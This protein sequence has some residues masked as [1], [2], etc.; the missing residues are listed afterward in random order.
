MIFYSIKEG[1]LGL[2]RAKFAAFISI[3]TISLTLSLLSLFALVT[4]NVTRMVHVVQERVNVELFIDNSMNE[5]SLNILKNQ[6][7]A[8]TEIKQVEY[9]T[10]EKALERF[11]REFGEDLFQLL[12]DNPL[13]A[14]FVLYL[15]SETYALN[16]IQNLE[17]QL[18]QI[19]GVEDVVYHGDIIYLIEKYSRIIYI[20]DIIL[21][22][23]AIISTIMLIANTLRLTILTQQKTIN[24]MKLVGATR[25]FILRPYLIQG[26]LEG[27]IAGLIATVILACMILILKWRFPQFVVFPSYLYFTPLYLGIILGFSGS[28]VGVKR[29]LSSS[30]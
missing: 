23:V 1:F 7:L 17:S 11:Q 21:F 30:F 19:R 25:L 29:F 24:I 4:Y 9:I 15:N 3:T 18:I 28:W 14:S 12:G 13:P 6:L 5:K 8:M 22:A 26:V 20:T 10:K 16:Q 2:Q 27:A